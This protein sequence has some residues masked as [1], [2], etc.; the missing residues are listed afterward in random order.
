MP[1][2]STPM[3]AALRRSK[4][5]SSCDD[6]TLSQLA[7]GSVHRTFRRGETIFRAGETAVFLACIGTGLV[8]IVRRCDNKSDAIVALFGPRET[9]GNLAVAAHGVYPVDAIATTSEVTLLCVN[10]DAIHDLAQR[11]SCV[12]GAMSRSLVEH[13]QALH[14]KIAIMSAG[15]VQQ[16]LIALLLHLLERFGD[17]DGSGAHF[18]PVALSRSDLASLVGATIE[19][20]IRAMS[21]WQKAGIVRTVKEGLCIPD[22]ARLRVMTTASIPHGPTQPQATL[23]L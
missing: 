14:A 13:G 2:P 3:V 6:E 9:I 8:K 19:T 23:S 15:S 1:L 20:T 11:S 16:R 5:F 12:T 22:P 21:R 10:A 18:I 17:E 7:R 4:L